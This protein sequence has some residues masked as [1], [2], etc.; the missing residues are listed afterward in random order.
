MLSSVVTAYTRLHKDL[1]ARTHDQYCTT[2]LRFMH[3]LAG[4]GITTAHA[5]VLL[6]LCILINLAFCRGLPCA[7]IGRMGIENELTIALRKA[8]KAAMARA[9]SQHNPFFGFTA[10]SSD[11]VTRRL[12]AAALD[13]ARVAAFLNLS[14]GL[15]FQQILDM[16]APF[17]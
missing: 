14:L 17:R 11:R 8:T 13:N 4:Y 1:P 16:A 7:S 15:S 3:G 12:L 2:L 9:G 10:A 6:R 5:V